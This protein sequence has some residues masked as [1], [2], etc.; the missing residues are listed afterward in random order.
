MRPSRT[1]LTVRSSRHESG[2][3]SPF[4]LQRLFYGGGR[5]GISVAYRYPEDFD[6]A[7]AGSQGSAGMTSSVPPP[8]GPL[9]WL[10]RHAAPSRPRLEH[11]INIQAMRWPRRTGRWGRRGPRRLPLGSNDP[12][13]HRRRLRGF[14][15]VF[16][17]TPGRWTQGM[18]QAHPW[19]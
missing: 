10:L 8:Y 1:S 4:L 12:L 2:S 3:R 14:L 16:D 5:Q 18:L 6:G 11:P 9:M 7:I 17:T 19:I 15:K 13:V